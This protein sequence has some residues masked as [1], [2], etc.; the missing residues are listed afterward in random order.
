VNSHSPEEACAQYPHPRGIFRRAKW[1]ESR[2]VRGRAGTEHRR[3][4]RWYENNR[5]SCTLAANFSTAAPVPAGA[6]LPLQRS[7]VDDRDV[8][9]KRMFS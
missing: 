4:V 5:D 9:L 1:G 2:W 8:L 6:R 7:G 3:V